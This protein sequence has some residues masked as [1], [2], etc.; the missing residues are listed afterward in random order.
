MHRAF[1]GLLLRDC[2]MPKR[3]P[4]DDAGLKQVGAA[5][6]TCLESHQLE[7][8]GLVENTAGD[9]LIPNTGLLCSR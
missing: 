7:L 6:V 2:D 9:V 5:G 3:G 1:T 4:G 8:V